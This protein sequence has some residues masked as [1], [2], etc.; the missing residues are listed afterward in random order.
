MGQLQTPG[1]SLRLAVHLLERLLAG[2]AGGT[3]SCHFLRELPTA[4][5][6]C[7]VVVVVRILILIDVADCILA[8]GL[9]AGLLGLPGL[10]LRA[11]LGEKLVISVGLGQCDRAEHAVVALSVLCRG[12]LGLGRRD[13]EPGGR[14]CFL[15]PRLGG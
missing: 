8:L 11:L 14:R 7:D 5:V 1:Q 3:L 12:R 6:I 4:I 9:L 2:L 13:K 15:W 10:P